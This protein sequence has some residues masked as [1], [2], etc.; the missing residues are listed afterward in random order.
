MKLNQFYIDLLESFGFHVNDNGFLQIKI[1]GEYTD[2]TLRKGYR[3]AIPTES[4][5]DKMYVKDG[6]GKYSKS[7]LI[8]NPLSEQVSEDGVGLDL[9]LASTKKDLVATFTLLGHL[10]LLTYNNI[11]LQQDLPM[12][13]NNFIADAKDSSVPGM[14][15]TG[16][17][18]DTISIKKWEKLIGSYIK[19][20]DVDLF[21]LILPRTKRHAV[22]DSNTREAKLTLTLWNDLKEQ[23]EAEGNVLVNGVN[24]RPKDIKVFTD[25]CSLFMIGADNKGVVTI[26]TKDTEAPGFIALMK[27]RHHIFSKTNRFLT[28]MKDAD[29]IAVNENIIDLDIPLSEIKGASQR[30]KKDLLTIPNEHEL[31]LGANMAN[32][33]KDINA[34]IQNVH[35]ALRKAVTNT[36]EEESIS[37][38]QEDTPKDGMQA[39]LNNK[40]KMFMQ[41]QMMQGMMQPMNMGMGMNMGMVNNQSYMHQ[42]PVSVNSNTSGRPKMVSRLS[43]QYNSPASNEMVM[44]ERMTMN[45][46]MNGGMNM[47]MGIGMNQGMNQGMGYNMSPYGGRI[48]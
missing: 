20:T 8:F 28:A 4:N 29:P 43:P 19:S 48:L 33:K 10:M 38:L 35:P 17:P 26:G 16:K 22:K 25:I 31:N 15:S 23:K 2:V 30:F 24:L 27:L 21:N 13:L 14:K 12:T 46:G 18:V 40:N 37:A 5:L 32:G 6:N 42:S 47:G 3:I 11:K 9:L 1:D 7:Y 34:N 45:S 44:R 39:L 41:S 36:R